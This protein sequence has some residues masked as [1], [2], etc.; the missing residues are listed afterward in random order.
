MKMYRENSGT[1]NKKIVN[2]EMIDNK[3]LEIVIASKKL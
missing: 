1:K 3:K 2:I